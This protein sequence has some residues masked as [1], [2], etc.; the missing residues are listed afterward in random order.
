MR[1]LLNRNLFAE[2]VGLAGDEDVEDGV[3]AGEPFADGHADLPATD[4][5]I[6]GVESNGVNALPLSDVE[7]A[8]VVELLGDDGEAV[9][10]EYF[11]GADHGVE[12]AE[13]GVVE[14]DDLFGDALRHEVLHH[15]RGFVVG[16]VG[17][18]AADEDVV[19]FAGPV[20]ADAGIESADIEGV[21]CT[22]AVVFARAEDKADLV[23]RNTFNVI[24]HPPFGATHNQYVADDD[25]CNCGE[26]KSQ[27][28]VEE[29]FHFGGQR[30]CSIFVVREGNCRVGWCRSRF[31]EDA[32]L[33]SQT[34]TE[35]QT[36]PRLS[37]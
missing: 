21:D 25:S 34:P 17:V 4:G 27:E 28:Y 31:G 30:F 9:E 33:Q 6:F 16:L 18:V 12:R 5:N 35:K 11:L 22:I 7:G 8:L 37:E 32:F 19:D 14:V 3:D 29:T 15:P 26:G 10:A 36:P 13:A 2:E 23:V 1:V 24:V 20:E